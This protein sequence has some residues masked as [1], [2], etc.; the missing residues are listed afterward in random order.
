MH[1]V[2]RDEEGGTE[3]QCFLNDGLDV[4]QLCVHEFGRAWESVVLLDR[5]GKSVLQLGAEPNLHVLVFREIFE[6][7]GHGGAGGV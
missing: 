4:G 5:S 6:Y 2:A 1:G 3:P 7:P